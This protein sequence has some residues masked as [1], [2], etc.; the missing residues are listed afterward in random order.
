MGDY[1]G[2]YKAMEEMYKVDFHT[3]NKNLSAFYNNKTDFWVYNIGV[4]KK[5]SRNH[6]ST[7]FYPPQC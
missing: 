5:W 1:Y 2:A 3:T 4:L 7:L 6:F